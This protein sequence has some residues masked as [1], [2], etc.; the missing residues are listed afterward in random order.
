MRLYGLGLLYSLVTVRD[1]ELPSA[2]STIW[3]RDVLAMN[4]EGSARP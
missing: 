3:L 4:G 2:M 1:A